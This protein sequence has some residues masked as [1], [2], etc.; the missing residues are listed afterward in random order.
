MYPENMKRKVAKASALRLSPNEEASMLQQERER[1]RKLRLQ[2]VRE[3]EKFIA[4][5]IRQDVKERKDQQLQQLAGDLRARWEAAQA[6]KLQALEK[7]YLCTLN[8][9]G[10]GH[11]QA[12][13]NEPDLKAIE[14][15]VAANKEKAKKRHQEA[16]KELKQQKEKQLRAQSW[17]IEARK[18]VLG[19]EK[20]RAA[21]IASLPPPPPDPLENIEV[22][23]RLPLVKV[24]NVDNFS[25]SHYHLPEAYVDREMDTEQ[26]DARSAA[27]EEEK[28]LNALLQEEERDRRE[29]M[30]KANLRGSH[31]LKMVQLA[32]D[33]DRLMKE[34]D[35]MQQ[36]DLSR[37][38]QIVA[39]MPQQLFEPAY[40]RADIREECQRELETA[41]EDM[42]TRNAKM[43]GDMVLHL[44]PQPLPD[45][46]VTSV[47]EDL[48]L[49]VE[50]EV[51]PGV[52]HHSGG[53]E[54][55]SSV[56]EHREE[57]REPQSNQV[58][59][60]LLKR[61]RTQRDQW[62][63][64][65]ET[66]SATSDTL[67][68]GSLPIDHESADIQEEGNSDEVTDTVIAGKS[69]LLHPEEQAVRIRM[70][71]ERKEKMEDLEQQ[72]QEQ[73]EL[74]RKLD[75][76]RRSLEAEFQKMQESSAAVQEEKPEAAAVDGKPEES[77]A[78]AAQLN[79]SAE[80]LH[81]QMIRQYQQRLMEQNRVHKQSVAEARKRLQEYQLLLKDRYPHLS[82]SNIG[83]PEKGQ[84]NM[85]SLQ[86]PHPD[87]SKNNIPS[88]VLSSPPHHN[89][90]VSSP[91]HPPSTEKQK[92]DQSVSR[93]VG[94][95]QQMSPRS[96][97]DPSSA[98][99]FHAVVSSKFRTD[100][101]ASVDFSHHLRGRSPQGLL[102][103]SP[104]D[105]HLRAQDTVI[106][107]ERLSSPSSPGEHDSS[108]GTSYFLLPSALY[109]GLPQDD[110]SEQ[111]VSVTVPEVGKRDHLPLGDFSNVQEFRE[112]LLSSAAE[113]SNQQDHLK[114]MQAQL[115]KQRESLLSK[116]K[117]QEQHLLHKQ[118]ELEEQI[119]R[120]QESLEELLGPTE[121]PQGAIPSDLHVIPERERYQFMSAL[122][123]ALEDEEEDVS[124]V[125]DIQSCD[126][127]LMRAPIRDHK[128]RPSKPPVTKTKLGPF[129]QQHELSAIM[130]VETPSGR[131]SSTGTEL[132][133]S[134]PGRP[135]PSGPSE[136]VGDHPDISQMSCDSS[137]IPGDLSGLSASIRGE[138][139]NQSRAKLSWRDTLSLERSREPA[140]GDP[141][142]TSVLY[143]SLHDSL[144]RNTFPK[145]LSMEEG[146]SGTGSTGQGRSPNSAC[147]SLSTTT[148]SSGSFLTSEKTDSSP[149]NC[150]FLS[151]YYSAIE[152]TKASVSNPSATTSEIPPPSTWSHCFSPAENHSYIQQIIEK[153]TKELS[154]SLERN[155]SFHSPEVATDV[156]ASDNHLS[157]TFH[158][159]DPNPDFNISTSSCARSD[160]ARS[161]QNMQDRS[162]SSSNTRGSPAV[163]HSTPALSSSVGL[164]HSLNIR[165][166]S[167]RRQNEAAPEVATD[168]TASDNHL[169]YTF[170]SVDPNPDFN[171]STSSCARS[172]AARSPQNMQDR[173]QSSSN[174]RGSPA[175]TH[176]T[177]ALSSSVGLFH[178]LNIRRSSPRRQN[179]ADFSGSFLPLHPECTL[180]EPNLS[181][182][183]DPPCGDSGQDQ[184]TPFQHGVLQSFDAASHDASHRPFTSR[185]SSTIL[186]SA[187]EDSGSFHALV[188]AQTTVNDSELSD[189][190]ISDILERNSVKSVH[191]EELP[192]GREDANTDRDVPQEPEEGANQVPSQP[193]DQTPRSENMSLTSRSRSSLQSLSSLTIGSSAGSLQSF[194]HT[195]DSES[196][197]GILEEPDLTLLSLNDSSIVCSE[198]P[199][200]QTADHQ[201]GNT[202]QSTFHPLHPEVDSSGFHVPDQSS[203]EGSL[204][205]HLTEMSLEFT[206]TPGSLQEAFLRKK[207]HLIENSSKRVQDIMKKDRV[208]KQKPQT[209]DLSDVSVIQDEQRSSSDPV[210][211]DGG[212]MKK[213]VEVRVSTPE[214]RKL[215]EIE[216]HQRTIRLYN[217]LHEVKTRRE[218][219]MR[220]ETYAKNREKAKD[221]KKR[222]LEKLRAKR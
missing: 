26:A 182:H 141:S 84:E 45:P 38:R 63:Y 160:A 81:I 136:H 208:P 61:I 209:S 24:C 153:Y 110:F 18:K 198:P 131:P 220:Q 89:A 76:E 123:K 213:V 196:M 50:P 124:M 41:F 73:L 144:T 95:T 200:T 85:R 164:F 147:D 120:R 180:N 36:E 193:S 94:K 152:E 139:P 163:T 177:P 4:Q 179:E 128:W 207:R 211:A 75:E 90:S 49:T 100:S 140:G 92:S 183:E 112:R 185:H 134:Q 135:D 184:E 195:W 66:V 172:D 121:P 23:K 20:E 70:E 43:R 145:P 215:T 97:P 117:S 79:M 122:L 107:S 86:G 101:P 221:F 169:S 60:R 88:T 191:F 143:K 9:I 72:K 93:G 222:T 39:K 68:S 212:Q 65:A 192:A 55:V 155:L 119:R 35:Q 28:R 19:I 165:R 12:K 103:H 104:H 29:Q 176:S 206:S 126:G 118:K 216:M 127:S 106:G 48:D 197:R 82:T 129:L 159:L 214:D 30:E 108:S 178:A 219:K 157:Y 217:R 148:I 167:P 161:P 203:A 59:K 57:V 111:V 53:M 96:G 189:H 7:I 130:E 33:R 5:Q 102:S 138:T 1:R 151:D 109:L 190:P 202:S 34:L 56:E 6:E 133:E 46:S 156:T 116:Q 113:I 83:S 21:K 166:S 71:A 162:Q 149:G 142:F 67:E 17:L 173:S 40:R 168:V 210:P 114:E 16:L 15:A 115:D 2:Q 62:D 58:L 77:S 150:D 10:E 78:I 54:D 64:Q 154:A 218:D 171:I 175:V 201:G 125:T 11:R 105:D 37:R 42:Y 174:T 51:V 44:K 22:V 80:G 31:A 170:H 132:R 146:A 3:Q 199:L 8:A 188:A 205:Q 98:S 52:E 137:I 186:T 27:V 99:G 87:L 74:I 91:G 181:R 14:K 47:D 158:S 69:I 204:S 32:Q 13:E 187:A 194:I 25:T